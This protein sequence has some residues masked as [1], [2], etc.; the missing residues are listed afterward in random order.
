MIKVDKG[1]WYSMVVLFAFL[2]FMEN[3]RSALLSTI[4]IYGN[5]YFIYNVA[6]V[7]ERLKIANF[8]FKHTASSKEWIVF[9]VSSIMIWGAFLTLRSEGAFMIAVYFPLLLLPLLLII[10]I[11]RMFI[12]KL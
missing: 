4:G 12:K 9:F 7:Y 5:I 2:W 6:C 10:D 3:F 1:F 8:D 11:F